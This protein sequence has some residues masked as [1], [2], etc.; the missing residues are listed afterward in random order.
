[1]EILTRHLRVE[2]NQQQQCGTDCGIR[3]QGQE[4]NGV[5]GETLLGQVL[6]KREAILL[7]NRRRH[8]GRILTAFRELQGAR[9]ITFRHPFATQTA[10]SGT[11]PQWP[12]RLWTVTSSVA[13]SM[14]MKYVCEITA[15]E[16]F[17]RKS[18]LA[19]IGQRKLMGIR[20]TCS[21][22]FGRKSRMQSFSQRLDSTSCAPLTFEDDNIEAIFL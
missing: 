13:S 1:M 6:A 7:Q 17:Q 18:E 19:H 12:I 15:M 10:L 22:C 16:G 20:D 3:T 11:Q 8:T 2:F 5:E 9:Q 4:L 21:P 14:Q